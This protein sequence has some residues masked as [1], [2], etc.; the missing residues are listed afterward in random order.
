MM[1]K[2]LQL[3]MWKMVTRSRKRLQMLW[4]PMKNLRIRVK[5][6]RQKRLTER[7]ITNRNFFGKDF[8]LSCINAIFEQTKNERYETFCKYS[9]FNSVNHCGFRAKTQRNLMLELP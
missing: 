2:S 7:K 9:S 4:K 1:T 5:I 6:T 8:D 3:P